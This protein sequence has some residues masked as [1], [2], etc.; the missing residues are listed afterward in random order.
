L[1]VYPDVVGT[2]TQLKHKGIR[3][4]IVTNVFQ[5]DYEQILKRL[6]LTESF[7]VA[8]GIDACRKAKP[9][10]EIFL[11]AVEKLR[12]PPEEALFIGDSVKSDFEG[13][14]KCGLKAF[15]HQSRRKGFG[16]RE[17]HKK[18]DRSLGVRLSS[19]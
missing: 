9:D 19:T 5:K 13:S 4:G 6:A 7:D 18:L 1:E 2:L 15:A 12:V 8:V 14:K 11:Y 10:I 17:D 16:K 3:L